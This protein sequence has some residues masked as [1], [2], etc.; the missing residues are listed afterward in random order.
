MLYIKFGGGKTIAR[1]LELVNFIVSSNAISCK[2]DVGVGTIFHHH[3]CGCVVHDDAII[4]KDCDI[5][6]NV[7]IG[8]KW[9]SGICEGSCPIIGNNVFI[10]AGAVLLGNIRIGNNCIIGANAVVTKDM[11]DYSI[12]MGVPA[13]I[14]LRKG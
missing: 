1:M 3:G 6:Q 11:P 9:G 4:G 5:F 7:T 12:A 10:G 14:A 8:S 2:A 13:K